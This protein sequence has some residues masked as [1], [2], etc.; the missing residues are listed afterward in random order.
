MFDRMLIFL[1]LC[2]GALMLRLRIINHKFSHPIPKW[3]PNVACFAVMVLALAGCLYAILQEERWEPV[4]VSLDVGSPID[5]KDPFGTILIIHNEGKQRSISNVWAA[6][7]WTD[8]INVFSRFTLNPEQELAPHRKQGL[9]FAPQTGFTPFRSRTFVNV[10]IRFTPGWSTYET[11][12]L[13]RFC[14]SQTSNGEYIWTPASGGERL[15]DIM[16]RLARLRPIDL[17]P[18]LDVQVL[19]VEDNSLK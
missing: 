9:H 16:D 13:F 6:M 17:I 14:V 5:P 18:L 2:L 3:L 7:H 8:G 19:G 4:N 10:E 11:N 12:Q 15:K 1:A